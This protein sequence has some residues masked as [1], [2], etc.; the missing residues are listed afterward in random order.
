MTLT[1]ENQTLEKRK[2]GRPV[3]SVTNGVL[4]WEVRIFD[5][6][7]NTFREGKFC[8]VKDLNEKFNLNLTN[9]TV[10]RIR[11]K[12]R[13]EMTMRNKENSFLARYGH[14]QIYKINEKV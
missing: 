2:Q 12:Y 10:R 3:G 9:D 1:L 11:T 14:I 13:V 7:T 8:S 6:E 5:K 4:K